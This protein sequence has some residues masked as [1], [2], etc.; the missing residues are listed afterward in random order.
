VSRGGAPRVLCYHAASDT[1][2]HALSIPAD[3][4]VD[5]VARLARRR[6]V[7]VTFDDAFR[8]VANVLPRL[9]GLGVPV[10]IFACPHYA[11]GGAPLSVPELA[12]E[13]ADELLTMPWEELL[14]WA[15]RGVTIASHTMTH[16]HLPTLGDDEL[17]RE[18]VEAKEQLEERLRTPCRTLA[19]P[20]G[21]NDAR[22]RAAAEAAGYEAAYG[23]PG[24][25]GERFSLPR[26]GV[27][28]RDGG[29]RL[30]LKA[31]RLGRVI[32]SRRLRARSR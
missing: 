4:I 2:E 21:E 30:A 7:H 24:L 19:F 17:R 8:S 28:R 3:E 1:W 25:P 10:T 29:M 26:V 13:P 15:A 20:Y 5:Q 14:D 22:V 27:Y 6:E 32:S 18:L 23:L 16:P 31:S 9:L 11:D 12:A